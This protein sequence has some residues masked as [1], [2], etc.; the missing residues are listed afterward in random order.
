MIECPPYRIMA[1]GNFLTMEREGHLLA[2]F[3]DL[4]IALDALTGMPLVIEEMSEGREVRF[5]TVP[6]ALLSLGAGTTDPGLLSMLEELTGR[7]MALQ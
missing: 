7:S 2:R 1:A 3:P 6:H 5:V 4:I